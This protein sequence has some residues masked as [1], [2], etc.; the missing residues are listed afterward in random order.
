MTS[1]S[2]WNSTLRRVTPLASGE[3]PK[4]TTRMPDRT[5][6]IK[7]RRKAKP[8]F[9]DNIVEGYRELVRAEPCLLLEHPEHICWRF[10]EF[11]HIAAGGSGHHDR[12]NG[13]PLCHMAH[14]ASPLSLHNQGETDFEKAWGLRKGT[15]RRTARALWRRYEASL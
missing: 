9:P 6:R 2:V 1:R 12:A 10:T 4:R 11:A 14:Q 13:V 15:L 5:T 3:G 8:R 7:A